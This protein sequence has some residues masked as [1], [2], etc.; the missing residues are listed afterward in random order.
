[1]WLHPLML[2]GLVAL[3]IPVA[4]HLVMR[5]RPRRVE[6]PAVRFVKESQQA[7]GGMNRLKHFLL[8]A[9][10]LVMLALL[11]VIL[12]R[13]MGRAGAV[14][15]PEELDR[16]P[17]SVVLCFDNSPSMTYR[18]Q[19]LSR[20]EQAQQHA[21]E[22]VRRLP[23]G[24]RFAVLDLAAPGPA[25][26]IDGDA[27]AA[28]QAIARVAPCSLSSNV[29]GLLN[30]A[31]LL[32]AEGGD[33]TRPEIYLFT[34]MTE[35]AWENVPP[36]AFVS[37]DRAAVY[38]L[39]VGV[40]ENL[41]VWLGRPELSSPMA[42][43]HSVVR[44]GAPITAGARPAGRTVALELG[45]QVRGRTPVDLSQPGV[46]NVARFLE[47]MNDPS[48]AQG[49]LSLM[50]TDPVAADNVCYFTVRVGASPSVAVVRGQGAGQGGAAHLVAQA[51]A[52]EELL[53]AGQAT[54]Q[55]K[56]LAAADLGRQPL[57]GFEAVFL[58]DVAGISADGWAAL[59][60]FVASGGGLVVVLGPAVADELSRGA[61]SYASSVARTL[62]GAEL[63]SVRSPSQ[64]VRFT[65]P[66]Y[67]DSVLLPFDRGQVADLGRPAVLKFIP[68]KPGA[69]K[70]VLGLT[71][72]DPALIRCVGR[73]GSVF[74]LAT[75][76]DGSW[77]D[78]NLNAR[79][80]EF[81]VLMHSL[82]GAARGEFASATGF[83]LGQPIS[84]AFPRQHAGRPVT[85]TGPGLATP[86]TLRINAATATALLPPLYQPG[87]YVLRV[88]GAG[89]EETFG[90][91]LNTDPA[92]SRPERRSPESIESLFARGRVQVAADPE[93]LRQTEALLR[94]GR[95]LTGWFIPL[96]MAAMV[97]EALLANRFHRRSAV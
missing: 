62:L 46:T 24:S 97:G 86:E 73:G 61:S 54:V 34:D 84:F 23:A 30:A 67:E 17:A 31:E 3:A 40:T 74:T 60:R 50:E 26:W 37:Y 78:L 87:N 55:P 48:L 41:N 10:R 81:V 63:G 6:F 82:L 96:L 29:G 79:A 9:L 39:D 5:T 59:D 25:R 57:N 42:A 68:L 16:V 88:A 12:A 32:L 51:L 13:P 53:L 18:H 14:A 45:G 89:G 56:M 80:D 47:T 93:S 35:A 70:T 52:P 85:L 83:E 22:I 75:S 65:V 36:A 66:S 49:T 94:Q 19:G 4:I 90:F 76:P 38:V 64:P 43:Q 77:S 20:L 27:G 8:L 69:A 28:E 15:A 7:S 44:I 21:Q 33:T 92:E 2:T 71:T 11:V 1:M 58:V 91:S 72:G 95:E